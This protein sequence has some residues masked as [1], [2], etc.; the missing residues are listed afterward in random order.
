MRRISRIIIGIGFGTG[1]GLAASIAPLPAAEPP[2][3]GPIPAQVLRVVDGD[4]VEV[5]ARIWLGQHVVTRVRIAGIDTPE[6]TG[7]CAAER[8][9]AQRASDYL[10]ERLPPGME[11]TL[12]Q[13]TLDKYGGRVVAEI[14][15]ARGENLGQSLIK[16]GLAHIYDGGKKALWCTE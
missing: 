7:K 14:R 9:L 11:A 5:E 1:L 6:K 10:S 16:S 12:W 13:V 4:T 2:L 15:D 3:A 8:A